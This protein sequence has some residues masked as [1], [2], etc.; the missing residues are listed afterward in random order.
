MLGNPRCKRAQLQKKP[1]PPRKILHYHGIVSFLW[2]TEILRVKP[3]KQTN[4]TINKHSHFKS[5]SYI[6]KSDATML[7]HILMPT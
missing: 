5:G 3:N 4:K 7:S 2:E 1:P 6:W